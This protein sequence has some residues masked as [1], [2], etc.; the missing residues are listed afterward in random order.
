MTPN[1]IGRKAHYVSYGTPGGEYGSVCRAAVI[2][3]VPARSEGLP[4]V[5]GLA[6]LN[7]EGMFFKRDVRYDEG[8]EAAAPV[9][10]QCGS[11][12]YRGGSWHWPAHVD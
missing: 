5:A 8:A 6:V 4:P 12:L 2:T 11:R 7:P 3:E 9:P 10:G 1:D